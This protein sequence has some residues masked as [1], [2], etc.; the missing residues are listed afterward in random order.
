MKNEQKLQYVEP[1]TFLF[2]QHHLWNTLLVASLMILVPIFGQIVVSGWCVAVHRAILDGKKEV[3]ELTFNDFMK[4]FHIGLGPFLVQMIMGA[5]AM[6]VLMPLY[7]IPSFGWAV[8]I[9]MMEDGLMDESVG[10]GLI[11]GIAGF[12]ALIILAISYLF[13][14][15]F[16]A[17]TIR[18]E[19]TNNVND[20]MAGLNWGYLKTFTKICFRPCVLAIVAQSVGGTILILIGMLLLYFGMIPATVVLMAAGAHYRAQLYEIYLSRGGEPLPIGLLPDDHGPNSG[21]GSPYSGQH[22]GF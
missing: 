13:A 10:I 11:V 6:L 21:T 3:P 14:A 19:L 22:P 8:V 7:M 17:A 9:V 18:A 2:K 1:F 5:I 12:S 20:S 16:T 4:Y 15:Y